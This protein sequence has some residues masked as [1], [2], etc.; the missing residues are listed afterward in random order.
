MKK[1]FKRTQIGQMGG[2]GYFGSKM[3]KPYVCSGFVEIFTLLCSFRSF[4]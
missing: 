3:A 4:I 2:Y 1:L